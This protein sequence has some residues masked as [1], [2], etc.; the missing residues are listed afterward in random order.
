MDILPIKLN[1]FRQAERFREIR[2][3]D[4]QYYQQMNDCIKRESNE[5]VDIAW[6][7]W[8]LEK[9]ILEWTYIG[10][11]HL[12]SFV[13]SDKLKRSLDK[14]VVNPHINNRELEY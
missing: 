3:I 14:N 5:E 13:T 7:L 2:A 11:K 12:G 8:N 10:H 4:K 6:P 9:K 1:F